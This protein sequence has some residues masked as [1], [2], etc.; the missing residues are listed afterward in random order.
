MAR[1]SCPAPARPAEPA[2]RPA[3]ASPGQPGGA[4]RP[5][6][7]QAASPRIENT[8]SFL[9]Q[10]TSAT[11]VT[12]SAI[13]TAV[14][15]DRCALSALLFAIELAIEREYCPADS[16]PTPGTRLASRPSQTSR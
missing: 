11:T 15:M 14:E 16:R 9:T 13:I 4:G 6:P 5:A 2:P 7:A 8:D 1:P 12:I 10:I 3:R